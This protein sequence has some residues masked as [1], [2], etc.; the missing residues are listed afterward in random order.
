MCGRVTYSEIAKLGK[1]PTTT[2]FFAWLEE[3]S[4][5]SSGSLARIL[6]YVWLC[7]SMSSF[8]DVEVRLLIETFV[9]IL[10]RTLVSFLVDS[11][12]ARNLLKA[13]LSEFELG[14][15]F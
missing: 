15:Q 7:S 14:L 1:V 10:N 2:W 5:S 12:T 9:A 4:V 8:V 13:T 11:G 3:V 6:T